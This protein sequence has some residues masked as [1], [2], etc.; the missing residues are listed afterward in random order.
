MIWLAIS[1]ELAT[2]I[3]AAIGAIAAIIV[4]VIQSK[5][6]HQKFLSDI[7]EQNKLVVYRLEQLEEK[8][9]RHNNFDSRLVALEE[10]VKT[11]FRTRD[12]T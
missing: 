11:L 5:A 1:P 4:S 8:V 6:Q 3:G 7:S 10:Q 2:I 12:G 9:N